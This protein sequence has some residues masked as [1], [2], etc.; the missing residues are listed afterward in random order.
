MFSREGERRAAAARG[1]SHFG[2]LTWD[3]SKHRDQSGETQAYTLIAWS[4]K[5]GKESGNLCLSAVVWHSTDHTLAPA[6]SSGTPDNI[7]S[8][9]MP[10][11]Q[12][13]KEKEK[14][15]EYTSQYNKNT[16][17]YLC[18]RP[19][20]T[21]DLAAGPAVMAPP[22]EGELAGTD[23]THGRAEVWDPDRSFRTK[24]GSISR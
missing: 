20:L 17:E 5:L 14:K 2:L 6:D 18:S 7:Y 19:K 22:G 8:T 23:H 3:R 4:F 15:D 16:S 9:N 24:W 1:H 21:P 10:G 11:T 12:P 13:A